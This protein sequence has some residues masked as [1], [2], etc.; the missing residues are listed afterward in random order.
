MISRRRLPR[1]GPQSAM[2]EGKDHAPAGRASGGEKLAEWEIK[3]S[4]GRGL[5]TEKN[6][7]GPMRHAN[8]EGQPE[9]IRKKAA[10]SYR[11]RTVLSSQSRPESYSGNSRIHQPLRF[12]KLRGDMPFGKPFGGRLQ[13][14]SRLAA[15]LFGHQR[16]LAIALHSFASTEARGES[17]SVTQL[18]P[19][20]QAY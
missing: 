5:S 14:S 7:W 4:R 17:Q 8:K 18:R 9:R 1:I 11:S 13:R 3:A 2:T 10:G 12:R 15:V 20:S 6:C 19:K 16:C